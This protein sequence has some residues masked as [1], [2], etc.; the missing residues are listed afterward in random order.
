MAKPSV[1][2]HLKKN[3]HLLAWIAIGLGVVILIGFL[4]GLHIRTD[5]YTE[6]SDLQTR[7]QELISLQKD[8]SIVVLD[9]QELLDQIDKVQDAIRDFNLIAA[10]TELRNLKT[11]VYSDHDKIEEAITERHAQEAA[12]AQLAAQRAAAEA[13]KAPHKNPSTAGLVQLPILMYHKPPSDFDAQMAALKAKGYTTVHMSDVANAFAGKSSLPAKPA[14]VTFDDGFA[15]QQDVMSILQKYNTK[16]TLYLIVGGQLSHYCIGL[17]RI[18][19]EPCGDA[20]LSPDNVRQMSSSGLVEIGAHTLDHP[21]LASMN[22]DDQW[23]QI[24]G[25]KEYL[26]KTFGVNVTSFAYP[27]GQYN[28]TSVA[29]VAK[30]GFLTAVTTQPGI[31][32]NPQ[33]PYLLHR[34]R[35]VSDLP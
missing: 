25:S 5:Q 13:A 6:L 2:K 31:I 17:T 28:A 11:V 27:Y 1:Q 20:Y 23:T 3:H 16:V 12:Q 15:A 10:N 18:Q 19:G 34:A 33:Q 21:N 35:A 8:N 9:Q 29:L 26:Q 4:V 22:A 32:Q 14:V 30:A 7:A 24:N